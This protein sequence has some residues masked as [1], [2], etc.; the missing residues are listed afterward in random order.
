MDAYPEDY[1]VH[2]LPFILI[3]GL[4]NS[5]DCRDRSLE[6]DYP[7]LKENGVRIESDFPLLIGSLADDICSAF[8]DYDAS[9]AP[10]NSKAH[11]SQVVGNGLRVKIIGRVSWFTTERLRD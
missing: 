3:S 7:L 10:W 4:G 11:I 9:D 2:N 6:A 8:R 1:V 5:F